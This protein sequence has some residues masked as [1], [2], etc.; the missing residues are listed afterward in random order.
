MQST[1]NRRSRPPVQRWRRTRITAPASVLGAAVLLGG[2]FVTQSTYNSMLQQQQTLEAALRSEISTDQ[3]QIEQLK[4][5]I[6]VRMASAL[7]YRE[8][9][10]DLSPKGIAALDKV[11]P[12]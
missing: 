6:R 12:Q 10:V 7:L 1:G 11:A 2:C 4:D 8:G 5:G 3:V 9:A